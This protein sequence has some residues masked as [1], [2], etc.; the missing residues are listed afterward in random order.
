MGTKRLKILIKNVYRKDLN[1][2]NKIIKLSSTALL[3]TI[4]LAGCADQSDNSK[5]ISS[6]KARSEKLAKESSKKK[7]ESK[8]KAS[9]SKKKAESE[10]RASEA[11]AKAEAESKTKAE[12]EFN[13]QQVTPAYESSSSA[14][15]ESNS[16]IDNQTSE[17][18]SSSQSSSDNTNTQ[19][20]NNVNVINTPEQAV[21]AAKAKFGD[22]NGDWI[23]VAMSPDE[24]DYY[25]VKAISKQQK[26]EGSMTGT[27][28]DAYVYKNGNVIEQPNPF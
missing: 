9:E 23:W 16:N 19:A 5:A 24:P 13:S 17:E 1:K 12:S 4:L 3:A 7:E 8:R 15:S 27:A 11:S 26:A 25:F 14:Q 22:N 21:E 2:L 10:R 20:T 6:S 28:F 18:T